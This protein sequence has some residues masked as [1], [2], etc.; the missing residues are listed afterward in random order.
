MQRR[1]AESDSARGGVRERE[2]R[3]PGGLR[4]VAVQL[5]LQSAGRFLMNKP[6]NSCFV[7]FFMCFLVLVWCPFFLDL[8]FCFVSLFFFLFPFYYCFGSFAHACFGALVW[9]V[10][11]FV[12]VE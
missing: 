2:R 10:L 12:C 7:F 5:S 6:Q 9:F 4:V 3:T 8:S 1:L 11:C